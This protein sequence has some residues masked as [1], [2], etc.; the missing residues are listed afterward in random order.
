[1]GYQQA[2]SQPRNIEREKSD[3]GTLS[4]DHILLR[5]EGGID[6]GGK[7]T[8]MG[9][10]LDG[11]E[12]RLARTG[13]SRAQPERRGADARPRRKRHRRIHRHHAL[14][15]RYLSRA[16]A[17]ASSPP[18]SNAGA[19]VQE[20]DGRIHTSILPV[21][22]SPSPP[23]TARRSPASR[24]S[25]ATPNSPRRRCSASRIQARSGGR[26]PGLAHRQGGD[27][28]FREAAQ[29]EFRSLRS[30]AHG[31]PDPISRSPISPRFPTWSGSKCLSCR[32]CGS[33][34]PVLP[35]GGSP[36]RRAHPTRARSRS[37]C[38]RKT[39]RVTRRSPTPGLA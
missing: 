27:P 4:W 9:K 22:F 3:A 6:P 24:K 29:M 21:S 8:G 16:S 35:N 2:A 32:A 19:F 23:P 1:M 17:Y 15:G 7:G 11:L 39:S 10:P 20:A 28:E 26:R 18:R 34:S 30:G 36:S 33:T 5:S 14:P 25:S 37:G 38:G 31:S 13:L 12:W